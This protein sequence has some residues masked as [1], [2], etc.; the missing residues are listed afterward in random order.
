[1]LR[2]GLST[3]YC[4][5]R[6]FI[7]LPSR[8]ISSFRFSST[9]PYTQE[10]LTRDL[11]KISELAAPAKPDDAFLKVQWEM[12]RTHK[13]IIQYWVQVHKQFTTSAPTEDAEN[14]LGFA[15]HW[16]KMVH[17]HH[18]LEEEVQFPA[19]NPPLDTSK[20]HDE[21]VQLMGPLGVFQAYLEA[22]SAG[23]EP[24]SATK[25]EELAQGFLPILMHHFVEELYTLDAAELKRTG[26]KEEAIK[27]AQL[28]VAEKSKTLV[29][30]TKDVPALLT[31]NDGALDW[32]PV[33]WPLSPEFK[34]PPQLYQAYK[35]WWKY[36]AAPLDL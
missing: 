25:A 9:M 19:W 26:V 21:H 6:R 12:A 7:T 36:S 23:S 11:G 27:A 24:W 30:P 34:M 3:S 10:D 35:G 13:A 2:L 17:T 5:R 29:D 1:M 18:Q 20:N 8:S 33:P 28:G 32:P 14:Y 15:K 4:A 16:V 31:H 22:V